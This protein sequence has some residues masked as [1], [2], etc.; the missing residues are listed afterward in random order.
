[1]VLGFRQLQQLPHWQ[2]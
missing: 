1:M 2:A